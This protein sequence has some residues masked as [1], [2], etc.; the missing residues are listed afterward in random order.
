MKVVAAVLTMLIL[1]ACQTRPTYRAPNGRAAQL[2]LEAQASFDQA[3][4]AIIETFAATTTAIETIE[5]AS[6]FV[7]AA[8][9]VDFAGVGDV[10]Q[11]ADLGVIDRA[12]AT[13][14]VNERPE[15]AS[16][17]VRYNVFVATNGA[18]QVIKV[19]TSWTGIV[20]I[21]AAGRPLPYQVALQGN[22]T[23]RFERTLLDAITQRL[24]KDSCRVVEEHGFEL[25]K[26]DPA[27]RN[28]TPSRPL[29]TRS[30][31]R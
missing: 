17:R 11:L 4:Q 24:P 29:R 20:E 26:F 5:K 16:A 13:S 1:T 9:P 22:S 2:S 8:R 7:A 15:R 28:W 31:P 10:A 21:P 23:G 18:T 14:Y 25:S 30:L 6:G 27:P 12:W 3:W 19:N